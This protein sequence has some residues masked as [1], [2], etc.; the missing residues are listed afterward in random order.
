MKF[1]NR[2]ELSLY[3]QTED[4]SEPR[5]LND[6]AAVSREILQTGLQN[7]LQKTVGPTKL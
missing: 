2:T 5:N 6:F 3:S 4:R 7:F 1:L